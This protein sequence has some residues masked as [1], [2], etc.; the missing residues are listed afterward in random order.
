MAV[1]HVDVDARPVRVYFIESVAYIREVY[2]RQNVQPKW[3]P[4]F[5]KPITLK[6][7]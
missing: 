3:M 7:V 6:F 5:V 1:R 2:K 4:A